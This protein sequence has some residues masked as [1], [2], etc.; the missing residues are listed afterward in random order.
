MS[1]G[2]RIVLTIALLAL[3]AIA[4]RPSVRPAGA[5]SLNPPP[6]P[7]V[8]CTTT[9]SG[10]ICRGTADTTFSFPGEFTCGSAATSFAIDENGTTHREITI[11]YDQAGNETK[12]VTHIISLV[13]TFTNAVTRTTVPESAHFVITHTLLTPGDPS[14]DQATVTGLF[15]KVV[16]PGGGIILQ[17]AGRVVFDPSG[18][19]TFEAGKHQF[20]DSQLADLCA[21]LT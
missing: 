6:P 16:L 18:D 10:T 7:S 1:C 3:M 2:G 17:D 8:T 14:T 5:A 13:G 21:A 11:A 9:G 4:T 15:A 20:T 19:I 12:R